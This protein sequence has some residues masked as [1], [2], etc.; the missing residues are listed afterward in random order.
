MIFM[1]F[2]P[3]KHGFY[4]KTLKTDS[5]S[6]D[7]IPVYIRN[8]F[9]RTFIPRQDVH[10]DIKM[11]HLLVDSSHNTVSSSLTISRI[12]RL[13]GFMLLKQFPLQAYAPT[14]H[15]IFEYSII[16]TGWQ[17]RDVNIVSGKI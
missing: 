6:R 2:C 14:V 8:H 1:N 17:I 3:K 10:L 7:I 13:H 11:Q 16:V 5:K 9:I 15:I 12:H 4:K